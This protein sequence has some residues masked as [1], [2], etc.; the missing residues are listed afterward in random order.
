MAELIVAAVI[1]VVVG[2]ILRGST[3]GAAAGAAESAGMAV[4]S[5]LNDELE[6]ARIQITGLEAM[7]NARDISLANL[8]KELADARSAA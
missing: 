3:G 8:E 4:S 6:K 5:A 1:G 2:W 7:V